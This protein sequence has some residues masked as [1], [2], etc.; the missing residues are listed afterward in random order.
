[1]ERNG[2]YT[3]DVIFDIATVCQKVNW[4][5]YQTSLQSSLANERVWEM[6]TTYLGG[7]N[8]HTENIMQIEAELELLEAGNYEAV[9]QMHDV[10]YF[11]DFMKNDYETEEC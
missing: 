9:V 7:Y 8:P 1:M 5:E 3:N 10:E 2:T 6:G 11:V 4:H